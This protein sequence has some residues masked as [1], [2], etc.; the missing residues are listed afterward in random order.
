MDWGV[1]FLKSAI[2]SIPPMRARHYTKT[3][4]GDY[5]AI[6]YDHSV[7]F[8]TVRGKVTVIEII[9]GL[10]RPDQVPSG[11]FTID[12]KGSIVAYEKYGGLLPPELMKT[13]TAP[14][15]AFLKLPARVYTMRFNHGQEVAA[16]RFWWQDYTFRHSSSH[17]IQNGL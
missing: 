8:E 3:V 6:T 11:L 17:T 5:A 10:N 1:A 16:G 2:L 9:I 4:A 13:Q 14:M 15:P 7:T 12:A